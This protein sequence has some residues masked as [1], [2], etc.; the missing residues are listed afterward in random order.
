MGVIRNAAN[1]QIKGK[2][3]AVTYYVSEGRQIARQ[4]LNN[5][6]Y[7]ESASR[8]ERQQTQRVKWANLVN[9]YKVCRNWMPKAFEGKK[10]GQSDYNR[11]MQV[12]MPNTDV[13][14]TKNEAAVGACVAEDYLISQ[15]SL[16][17]V[18]ITRGVNRWV[19]NI[20][21][22]D[23]T[24][25]D[26]TTVGAFSQALVENNTNIEYG[27]QI[28]YVSLMQSVDSLG[29]P[30]LICTF[31][32]VTLKRNSEDLLYDYLPNL[33]ASVFDRCL[34]TSEGVP[35]GAFAYVVSDLRGGALKVSTQVL[36]TNNES[37]ITQYTSVLQM[38]KAIMSY[39]LDP[40]V[41]LSPLTENEQGATPVPSWIRGIMIGEEL[42]K[43]GEDTPKT[44]T[45]PEGALIPVLFNAYGLYGLVIGVIVEGAG[46]SFVCEWRQIGQATD[47]LLITTDLTQYL[48]PDDTIDKVSVTLSTGQVL[49]AEFNV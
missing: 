5:S 23:L 22:G 9:F 32:E 14:L 10:A 4:A 12:N 48:G 20:Y 28:S 34:A 6:N 24:I 45:W 42:Y 41:V 35:I 13:Y 25:G 26:S 1:Q 46:Q 49:E 2:V 37:L 30:R 8:S 21:V 43:P 19:S 17:S 31:Y 47:Q 18:E 33:C 11:L 39:G 36:V 16:P 38:Q 44:S 27:M 3:G 29:I 15:G 40:G 7:G